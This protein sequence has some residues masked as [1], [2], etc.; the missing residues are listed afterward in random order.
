MVLQRSHAAPRL[1]LGTSVLEAVVLGIAL[2]LLQKDQDLAPA[3]A[4]SL[5]PVRD[6]LIRFK[7]LIDRVAR[8]V[9]EREDQPEELLQR[10]LRHLL[11]VRVLQALDRMLKVDMGNLVADCKLKR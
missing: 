11:H 2:E 8:Q 3:A 7:L 10:T 6:P 1:G 5:H 4:E 9:A